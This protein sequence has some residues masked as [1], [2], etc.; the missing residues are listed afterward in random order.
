MN[1]SVGEH[2]LPLTRHTEVYE[3]RGPRGP[4]ALLRVL[5]PTP[6]TGQ[7]VPIWGLISTKPQF[8]YR[9]NTSNYG[10]KIQKLRP[11]LVR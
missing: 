1:Q 5:V 11:Q 3:V 6:N 8:L 4:R 7:F 10:F 9:K 2:S